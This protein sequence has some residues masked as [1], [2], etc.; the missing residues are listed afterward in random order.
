MYQVIEA[1]IPSGLHILFAAGT[2]PFIGIIQLLACVDLMI[3]RGT[4]VFPSADFEKFLKKLP[5]LNGT[6]VDAFLAEAKK[7]TIH[8][9]MYFGGSLVGNDCKALFK[10]GNLASLAVFTL[11]LIAPVAIRTEDRTMIHQSIS[12]HRQSGSLF[13][14][15]FD[16][17]HAKVPQTLVHYSRVQSKIVETMDHWAAILVGGT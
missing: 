15:A 9:S 1:V 13:G 6:L 3:E 12:F 8:L 4:D 17:L 16:L 11:D 10:P 2:R 7:L 5:Y 14:E